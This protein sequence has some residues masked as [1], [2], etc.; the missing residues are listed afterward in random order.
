MSIV[1]KF[2]PL[3]NLNQLDMLVDD[4]NESRHFILTDLPESLPQGR[5][6]FLIETGPFLKEGIELQIDFVDSEGNSIYYEP[7]DDYLEG[8]SRRI[9]VEVYSDTGP[10]VANLIIVGELDSVPTSPGSFSDVEEV[11]EDWKGIYNVRLTK[12]IIINPTEINTEPIRF[13]TQPKITVTEKRLGSLVRTES[14]SSIVTAFN[15]IKG[16]PDQNFEFT[17]FETE[18]PKQGSLSEVKDKKTKPKG[19]TDSIYKM[20]NQ[21][22]N[23]KGKR[24]SSIFKR[25]GHIARS[26]SPIEYPYSFE[27]TNS[28]EFTTKDIGGNFIIK[29]IDST[30]YDRDQFENSKLTFPPTFNNYT[31]SIAELRNNKIALLEKPFTNLNNNGEEVI[32]PFFGTVELVKQTEPTSSYSTANIISYAD[33]VLSD[34]RTFSGDVFKAKV[35]VRS[36]GSFDD[37]KTLAEIPVESSEL[38]VDPLSVGL[39]EHTGYYENQAD[40]NSYWDVTGGTAVFSNSPLLDGVYVSGSV[41][42][43]ENQ[44]KYKLKDAYKF[45]LTKNVD[46]TVSFNAYTKR[47]NNSRSLVA[48]YISGSSFP[49]NS[50]PY[51]DTATNKTLVDDNTYG[52]RLGVIEVD[53]QSEKDL[54]LVVQNFT[55]NSTGNGV[56]QFRIVEGGWYFSDISVKPSEDTGFSPS[57]F[58]FQ[59]EMPLEFQHKRPDTFEFLV[60]FYDANDNIADSLAFNTGSVFTGGNVVIT[61]N[62]NIQ[63]GDMFLGGDTTGSGIHFG[64]VDSKLPETGE[65]G[66]EGSGFIRSIGYQGFVSASAQSGSYGFMIYSGSVLPNSGDNY[67]GVGLE[68]VG[69]SG[70]LKFR[71]KPSIF[72]VVADAFFV[73]SRTTQFISGSSGAVEISS[74]NFHLTP[75]G[76]VTMSGIITAEG[77]NIGDFKIIGGQISGSNMTF[78]APRS[79]L[80]KTDQGPGSDTTA[81]FDAKRNEYYIDFTP[82]GSNDVDGTNYYIKMGPNFMVDKDG[83]LIASGAE[84]VG[85]ITAS[86]GLIGGFTTDSHSF[87]SN[88]IFIS[89]SPLQGSVNDSKYMFIST[90]N[91]NVK[92]SGDVTGSKVLFTGG[93]L[94]GFNIN[95][96]SIRDVNNTVELS[97]ALPGLK[98]K[99]NGGTDRVLVKSGSLSTVGGGTQYI[100]NKSFEEQ[101]GSLSAGRNFVGSINS[102]SFSEGGAVNISLTDRNAFVD[103]DKAV[104]GRVTLDVVVP[105]GS[106]N[107]SSTNTYQISQVVTASIAAGDTLSFS[108]VARFSSSFGGRGK[109]RALQPQYFR[110]EYSGSGTNGFVPFLPHPNFTASNGYGEY[111]L[112][113][114]QYNSFGASA[115]LPAAAEFIKVVLTGSIN[116]DTGFTIEKPLFIGDK[117]TVNSDVSGRKFTKQVVGSTTAEHPETEI[118]FD[119][120]S[121]RSNSRRVEMTQEGLLIYNS[122]DSFIKMTGAGIEIRGGSGVANFG[123]AINREA[124]TNDSQVAGTLGAPALQA[125]QSDPE[126][127]GT[128]ASDGNVGE[129]AKGNHVHRL[130]FSTVN[131]V[132]AGQTLTGTTFNGLFGSN[133]RI[134]ISGSLGANADVIRS[135]NRD[136][137]SGS[138]G[139][140]AAVIR[141]LARAGISGSLGANASV[142]RTLTRT[143]ISGSLGSNAALIRSLTRVGISG[144]L[145]A[146]AIRDLGAGIL[147]G[148]A[149]SMNSFNITDGVTSQEIG[150]GNNITFAAG[151]GLDVAVSATDTVTYSA[152]VSDFMTNGANNRIIT[153]T[154]TDAMNAESNLTFDGSTL[155]VTGTIS[156]TSNI[157]LASGANL[158]F[159]GGS[160]SY[161]KEHS[162]DDIRVVAG[163]V[164]AFDFLTTG[165]GVP[166]TAKLYLD[167]GGNTHLRESSAD[168]IKVSAGGTDVLDITSVKV[169]GSS[170]STA[171]FSRMSLNSVDPMYAYLNVQ[172][173]IALG[174]FTG[175][176]L[177]RRIGLQR[178]DGAGWTNTPNINFHVDGNGDG[179]IKFSVI[180]SGVAGY[181]DAMVISKDGF[182]GIGETSPA[183]KLHVKGAHIAGRGLLSLESTDHAILNL[184]GASANNAGIEFYNATN[185]KWA[186]ANRADASDKMQIRRGSDD[187]VAISFDQSINTE[188]GGNVS[189]SSTSTGSFGR[190][191]SADDIELKGN[192]VI[193]NI[194]DGFVTNAGGAMTIQGTGNVVLDAGA[195]ADEVTLTTTSLTT[196][197]PFTGSSATFSDNVEIIS[198]NASNTKLLIENNHASA[199]AL[200]QLDSS[201]DRDSV[202]QLLE[203]GTAKWDIRND[204]NDSDKLK[205]SDDGDV[206]LTLDQ[207]G[208]VGI[209]VTSADA[210]LEVKGSDGSNSTENTALID[211]NGNHLF[212]QFNGGKA[213]FHYGPVE[214]PYPNGK[215][216][217]SSTTTASFGRIQVPKGKYLEFLGGGA[218][219]AEKWQIF[220]SNSNVFEIKSTAYGGS[221]ITIDATGGGV[222]V[223]AN[224]DVG[225]G[226]DVTGNIT[227]TGTVDG[228]DLATDGSKLDGIEANAKNDQT[229]TAGSGLTGGGTGDVTLNIGAGTGIDVAADA[230]SVDVSDFLS[231]GVDN[232]VVTATGTDGFAA[233]DG[234][235]FDGN[236][237]GI[238][239]KIFH[240]G[241]TDTFIR[242]T[243]DDINIQAGG[244]N[245]ID[246]TEDTTNEITFNEEGGVINVRM[247]SNNDANLFFLDG[248]NDRIGIGTG[249]PQTLLHL[250]GAGEMIR[251]ENNTNAVGNTFIS[252]YDTSALK[253][254]VGFT[255]G[256]TDHLVLYNN[257][258]A[259]VRFFTN[260]NLRMTIAAGGNV[261]IGETNPQYPLEVVGATG[262]TVAKFGE[263]F[264][265]HAIH[266]SPVLGFNLFYN[267]AYKLGEGSSSSYGGYLALSPSTGKFSFA[268]SNQGNAGDT[269]TMTERVTI[270]NNGNVGIGT[271]SPEHP[272][273]VATSGQTT[274]SIKAGTNKQA[275]IE[276]ENDG[277]GYSIGHDINDNGG[278]NFFIYDRENSRDM[279]RFSSDGAVFNEGSVNI[280]FRV[281]S[282]GDANALFIKGSTDNVGIGTA[283]PSQKLH[284]V[285]NA[286]I[287]GALTAR[288]FFTD[289]VSSSIQFT[290]GSTKFGDTS[291]DT[292]KFTGSI[293]V[294]SDVAVGTATP[295]A[296]LHVEAS[297]VTQK[298][299][300]NS[301]GTATFTIGRSV[302]TQAKI[303]SGDTA[304]SDFNI[305]TGGT[306][307]LT[308]LSSGNVGIGTTSP[309]AQLHLATASPQILLED[310]DVSGLKHTITGGGNAGLEIGVDNNNTGAGY[311]RISL[312]G[313][314]RVNITEAGLAE[315]NLGVSGSAASTGSFGRV[316]ASRV[317]G[318]AIF[319]ESDLAKISK[320]DNNTIRFDSPTGNVKIGSQNSSFLHFYTDRGKYFFNKRLIVDEGIFSSYNEDLVLQRAETTKLTL[321]NTITTSAQDF[322]IA[323]TKTIGTSTFISGITG[324]GFRIDDNGSDGTLLEIDNIVVRNTLR[325]HIFQ[326][327]V[328]KATNGILFISDSGV[329]SGSTGTTGTGTVTFED[330]KSATFNDDQ[331][332]LFKDAQDNGTINAV[333]F[334]INGSPITGGSVQSGF[335]KYNVDNVAGNLSNLNV[336]GTA[337]RISGGTVAIDASS[338]NSPFVDVNAAS[339]S[340]VVRMGNLAGITSPRFGTLSNQFGLWASGSAYLEGAINAKT[341]NIGT[342]GIGNTAISSSGGIITLDADAKRITIS[343]GSNDRIRLGE[344]DGGTVYGLKIFDGSG[345]TDNDILVELGQGGN[346]I[347]G[348][349]I[350]TGAITSPSS[351]ITISSDNK[352]ITINDGSNDRIYL[353]EVDGSTTYGLKIFDGTGTA[354]A[355][356][357]VELGQG[358][359]MIVGW[360]LVPG[361]L[362][363]DGTNG[364][365]ALDA[366][367]QQVA[368]YTGSIN[369]AQPK[370]VMGKLPR[371]GGSS[372]DDRFGFAV[373]SGSENA[374]ILHDDRFS[375]LITRDKAR[376]AGW[377]LVPGALRSGTVA[378]IN[379][380]QAKIALGVNANQ[381]HTTPQANLFYVS[382]SATPTFFVGENFSFINNT[383]TAAGWEIASTSIKK[384]TDVVIDSSAKSITLGNGSVAIEHNSGTP[385][386]RSAT[387]FTTGN[388]FFLSSAGTDNFRV[389]NASAARL[390][391]DGTNFKIFNSS[392]AELVSLGA[393]NKIAGWF[394][395]TTTIQNFNSDGGI[396]IDS[397]NKNIIIYSDNGSTERVVLGDVTG[398]NKY[399]I[400]G[401][402]VSGNTMFEISE[403]QNIVA[404][405]TL[406]QTSI[407]KNDVKLDST[408]NA[409]G[410]YVKKTSFS[411]TTAGGFLGLD[412]GTAKFNVGDA[413][414]FIKFDGTNFT[415]DAG[416][417]S[418]DSSGN[419]TATN[420][421]LSGTVTAD[422][423]AIGGFTLA[424][425]GLTATNIRI[426][427]T[428]ASMSLGDKVKIVGGTDSFIAMGNQFINDTNFSNFNDESDVGIIM[429][430]DGNSPKFELTDGGNNHLLFDSSTE[431][432][433][434]AAGKIQFSA[435][436][437]SLNAQ[438]STNTNNKLSLGTITTNTDTTG[439]GFF[440]DG[441]GN[442]RIIGS[443]STSVFISGSLIDFRTNRMFFGAT[444]SSFIS[445][446]NG[447]LQIS[448]SKF[449]LKPSGDVIMKGILDAESGGQIGGFTIGATTLNSSETSGNVQAIT[450][451]TSGTSPSLF[452]RSFNSS[453]NLKSNIRLA[454]LADDRLLHVMD[455]FPTNVSSQFLRLRAGVGDNE[456][457]PPD[458]KS[459]PNVPG[460]NWSWD[461]A[462]AYGE[463]PSSYSPGDPISST[464]MPFSESFQILNASASKDSKNKGL[465]IKYNVTHKFH[466]TKDVGIP[467][468]AGAETFEVLRM[469]KI[470]NTGGTFDP[471]Q[472]AATRIFHYGISGSQHTTASF[473]RIKANVFVGDGSQLTG[474]SGG[475]GG[476]MDNWVMSDGATTQ[477]VADGQTVTFAAGEGIDVAVTA[478][479][480]VTYSAEN[481]STS[482]K[483]VVELATTSE[484]TTG[485]DTARAVTP[486]GLKDGYQGSTNVT[487]LGTISTGTWNGTAIDTAY[488]DTSLTSQQTIFN[489]NLKIGSA[490]NDEYIDFT[491]DGMIMFKIDNAEDFRMADGGTFHANNDV[492]AFS[493]TISSD[494][495]LKTNIENINYGLSDVLKLNGRQ[496]DWKREDRGHDIGFIAQEV[497]EVIP[498]LVKEV[499]GLNGE[500][501]FK[502]VDYA[503]TTAV[504]VEAIKEQQKQIEDL[505]SEIKELKDGSSR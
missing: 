51:V 456:G 343:D 340:A 87:S 181:A 128:T 118:T 325:T 330:D 172:G 208:N 294:T 50:V 446:S 405:W 455:F 459:D 350:S 345:V 431:T 336:G 81:G 145:S 360:Q 10:G 282:N 344:V 204:G 35:M 120:F 502:T 399:G 25:I 483:G 299:I 342:W 411:S 117:G 163:G 285:G 47:G 310:T 290:S 58:T 18:Q 321:G 210:R 110:L 436:G 100:G 420:A 305:F 60:E 155:G 434:L 450:T 230:I 4:F 74:S 21:F 201:N 69:A 41:A 119:N 179:H 324:D 413:S 177:N 421:S 244:V 384:G 423:G 215:V 98:I 196:T 457:I 240:I 306:R 173:D 233:E 478:T 202:I 49:H 160:N 26:R 236:D 44:I 464:H 363:F 430:M 138:L 52:Y 263:T 116:D 304:A 134:A 152:D 419:V 477:T 471:T 199:N 192:A 266:N 168:N 185:Q 351:I 414:K 339:G 318:N 449:Q 91:F 368:I 276:F 371:V 327:D 467:A 84:F 302:D 130:T 36:E 97:S 109:D 484:T 221:P 125:Y 278:H 393:T 406:S 137:I 175:T 462:N 492:I 150:N 396:K 2:N 146:N 42:T 432:L 397:S 71:T 454:N 269:A 441:G 394:I 496:F 295:T 248:T 57:T 89:G 367:N 200:L 88:N 338:P 468:A 78:N 142:I 161:I 488:L 390:Q 231:N 180:D 191:F 164:T 361:R 348:W 466:G 429:G 20:G 378:D 12:E 474:V 28:D 262:N 380:N 3:K 23:K 387:N 13:Y 426:S 22:K 68:L 264:A 99:D 254:H 193:F 448:S 121:L 162:A 113:S 381:T 102:W 315:I 407:S 239:R 34:M 480:T 232:R 227:V 494:K 503:K 30:Q 245:F 356:R 94:G 140:N 498:E 395:T 385:I 169:S 211:G 476:S 55:P 383:L 417:F 358:D 300:S 108:S 486:D 473:G 425:G 85:T 366:T 301:G 386:I 447:V 198:S 472:A 389:G 72:E 287:D 289:I 238:T 291:D 311:F 465:T 308:I 333:R 257:E 93:K 67:A 373:F 415:V 341:G 247:E 329:I 353:G 297:S 402:D 61:G 316:E 364:S 37:F 273:Q 151:T 258:N 147:S 469:G 114:G 214:F 398:A 331:I 369:T 228:R 101:L 54:G 90:S 438:S 320:G 347:A 39:S 206:R 219:T 362:E 355:D 400:K 40:V 292:H 322:A 234:L 15:S 284:V 209:G 222:N 326:K 111:F 66:A 77:G 281:E 504:L 107:Y 250:V 216:S 48:I 115:D 45:E 96:T 388:G 495:K 166:A 379:G 246:I 428:Q 242:F 312:G 165:A 370:V 76:N 195:G 422:A 43:F 392:N 463:L 5:S 170:A 451:L 267:T 499:D 31:G 461:Y 235:T 178:T 197:V 38:M 286:F 481:A 46:Y 190:V 144:S 154:G 17:V 33:V 127:I 167:G 335:T 307:R 275:N 56:L 237:L 501:S 268:T 313:A 403:N 497:E 70:S 460:M 223:T 73:G 271:T 123:T 443:D 124:A 16:N 205:I 259:D 253:G 106:G 439:A 82:S 27:I 319:V 298:L 207:S 332:L 491:S 203:N 334:Q 445:A 63:S 410:L 375:V 212:T 122:E 6:S 171:S 187:A 11:P 229:I 357:L 105:A 79:Q 359:N 260:Q 19:K 490:Y 374:S 458:P 251:I 279:L 252:F 29:T 401:K 309:Q 53:D 32:I 500:E 376:L 92:Q 9:S 255:G 427:S 24:K 435:T 65:D 444:G 424:A 158:F 143:G 317:R 104:S 288:E 261:G 132:L 440:A 103:D 226:L 136:T 283:T 153:A 277:T 159:D 487:T 7:I 314:Q 126:D 194:S 337:A 59:K 189:G 452:L 141:T 272:L 377:D 293:F 218:G 149:G 186:I 475:G 479:D 493:S 224:L 453:T 135:L 256:S 95:N 129:F 409:E 220:N 243:N 391:F 354:D 437:F 184:R 323:D 217:G 328:V 270:L 14:S 225:A 75:Q 133:A 156:T 64:G 489:T 213:I 174:S 433:K 182:V 382:A 241:D 131:S 249:A 8:T 416:N 505:K 352:R 112:G 485:T 372:S 265:L 365:I 346:Q 408:T 280:D 442:F 80:F 183:T 349:T 296:D 176:N 303:T 86:A 157:L 482:N 62:D 1:K 404:G 418:L 148:S 412:S 470:E 274:L 139:S 83:I 188:F